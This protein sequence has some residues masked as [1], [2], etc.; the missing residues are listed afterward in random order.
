MK[1]YSFILLALLASWEVSKGTEP[2]VSSAVSF[3]HSVRDFG[4]TG[5]GEHDDAPALVRAI[6]KA[7][8]NGGGLVW[9]PSGSY[10]LDRSI[11]IPSG[12]EL[13]GEGV[14]GTRIL[15]PEGSAF[16]AFTIREA[17]QVVV[18]DLSIVLQGKE[19]QK[20]TGAAIAVSGNSRY[21]KFESVAVEGFRSAFS[22]GRDETGIT[23]NVVL[24]R[25][26]AQKAYLFGFEFNDVKEVA[27]ENCYASLN[28]LDGIKLRRKVF[29]FTVRGGESSHNG[30]FD[31]AL[32]GNGIDG[33]AGAEGVAIYDLIAEHNNGSGLYFKTGPLQYQGYGSVANLFF[34]GVRA[35]HNKGSG[36][37]INR[38]GGDELRE[39]ES[40]LPP[41]VSHVTVVG[42][43]FEENT[44]AGIYLRG[45]NITLLAPIIRRN[46][47]HG[48]AVSTAWDVEIIAPLISGNGDP[49]QPERFAGISIGGPLGAH[50]VNL[51]GG[52]IDGI[53]SPM[54]SDGDD[55]LGVLSVNRFLL[56]ASAGST[57]VSISNVTFRNPATGGAEVQNKIPQE[58][59]FQWVQAPWNQPSPGL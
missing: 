38:S 37:D 44:S 42:G 40:Q 59:G 53:D 4:A 41:L 22:F 12:V 18:A 1:I 36:L 27:M 3:G 45:R 13:R 24:K 2:T 52:V 30:V 21:L 15:I 35:R 39:G 28:R 47:G 20:G 48:I 19:Y 31:P 51:R 6:E 8:L 5:D 23:R 17:K 56:T 54:Q 32:N 10:R 58:S 25:C 16:D 7:A 14:Q 29:D 55:P 50:R 57:Q 34:S 26:K 49:E 11:A 9:L 43:L 33:Y 46:Q